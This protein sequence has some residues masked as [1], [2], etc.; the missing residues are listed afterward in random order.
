MHPT[1]PPSLLS[2]RDESGDPATTRS[3][4]TSPADRAGQPAMSRTFVGGE[5]IG[6]L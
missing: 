6:G 4:R 1:N 2:Q 5:L 3:A